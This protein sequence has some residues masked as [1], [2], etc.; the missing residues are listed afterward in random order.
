MRRKALI[1]SAP[2]SD[3]P[4]V[5]Q[6]AE[7]LHGY[8]LSARGGA[9]RR[10]EITVLS[11]PSKVLVE[12]HLAMLSLSCDYSFVAFGG[13][14]RYNV[15][16]RTTEIQL[17]SS[18]IMDVA[19]LR[20]GA[21]RHTL[22]LDTCRVL[23]QTQL[24]ER[25]MAKATADSYQ[26]AE[27]NARQ[28][29]DDHLSKSFPGIVEIYSC[30]ISETAGEEASGGYYTTS[31]VEAAK[32]WASHASNGAALSIKDAHDIASVAVKRK[33]GNRQNPRAGYPR[34]QPY[35]PFAVKG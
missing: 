30:D 10:D 13:H 12:V 5:K 21:A 7:N 25:M 17:S 2:G 1:I 18:E 32:L 34:S 14:G 35:F 29:F 3:L 27:S 33:T 24:N 23:Y 22:M 9:W 20:Q 28:I 15:S 4:G 19:S 8:L 26:F 6:D 16:K 11:D 31:L